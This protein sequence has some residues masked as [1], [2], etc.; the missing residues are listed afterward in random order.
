M[1]REPDLA[2]F[3]LV[4]TIVKAEVK[5]DKRSFMACRCC[6]TGQIWLAASPLD[7]A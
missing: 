1:D 7:P 4:E 2:V 3:V 6:G 5:L